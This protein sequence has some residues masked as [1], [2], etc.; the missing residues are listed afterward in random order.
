MGFLIYD[1]LAITVSFVHLTCLCAPLSFGNSL[2][3]ITG[4]EADDGEVGGHVTTDSSSSESDDGERELVQRQFLPPTVPHGYVFLQHHRSKLL[5]YMRVG[6]LRVLACGRMKTQ[7]YN[8][9]NV[10]RY[11]SAIC[12]ACQTAAL[13]E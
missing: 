8:A 3:T 7:A 9:P 13:R 2:N 1:F 11:D 4:A 6:D 5:H 10:L 12:H